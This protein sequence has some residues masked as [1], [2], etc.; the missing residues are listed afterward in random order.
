MRMTAC[1]KILVVL[2]ILT[3]SATFA[4]GQDTSDLRSAVTVDGIRMHQF[5]LQG[6]ADANGGTRHSGTSG[7][8]ASADYVEGALTAAGYAVTRQSFSFDGWYP[9]G[10]STLE[11]TAPAAVPY[12]NTVDYWLL[13]FSAT[14]DVLAPVTAV[15]LSL[16]DPASSTSGCEASDFAGFPAGHI[17][18]V[19][20]GYCFFEEKAV[21]AEA[22]GAVGLIIMNQGNTPDRTGVFFGSLR[23]SYS[24]TLPAMATT[25]DHGVEWSGTPGLEMHI[26]SDVFRGTINTSNVIA[27]T[28]GGN[29]D[30][31]VLIGAPLDSEALSPGINVD[32]SGVSSILE[33]ALQMANLGISPNNRL[34]FAFWGGSRRGLLGSTHYLDSLTP[35]EL[36]AIEMYLGLNELGS[37]NFARFVYDGDGSEGGPNGGPGSVEIEATFHEYYADLTLGGGLASEPSSF[38]TTD[39]TNFALGDI[40]VGGL[41]GGLLGIKTPAQVALY[42][43]TAGDRYDP[44][45]Y[46]ACDTSANLSLA[47]LDQMADAAAHGILVYATS[48]ATLRRPAVQELVTDVETLGIPHGIENGLLAKLQAALR[49]IDEGRDGAAINQLEAF[50]HQVEAKRGSQ[51]TDA[52]AD[53]LI[54]TAQAILDDLR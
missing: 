42:G 54:A 38:G 18:L 19:Q 16:A 2:S 5:A 25:F 8:D 12:F 11:Q 45:A 6:I 30:K 43:G 14:A 3:L 52:E 48:T 21:L 41:F 28:P 15:D 4:P 46:L 26:V 51:F 50:I 29:P 49:A 27:E 40:A 32:G 36:D 13:E 39:M 10:P 9:I 24:G 47:G 20:R 23:S 33:I 17:A 31:V 7:F 22:A 53:A 1:G 34:R 44:C 37:P 35:A